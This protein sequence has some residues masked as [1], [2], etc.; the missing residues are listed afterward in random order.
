MAFCSIEGVEE[1]D[2]FKTPFHNTETIRRMHGSTPR[3]GHQS[4]LTR[5]IAEDGDPD[6]D[7][8]YILGLLAS[9]IA[10]F[11]FFSIWITILLVLKCCGPKR[12]GFWS[13]CGSPLPAE[14]QPPKLGGELEASVD[15]E[16][17]ETEAFQHYEED[18]AEWTKKK[19]NSKRRLNIC[20]VVVLFCGTSII[21]C[22]A[23]MV[24][25]GISSLVKTLD[26]GRDFIK[27]V[28]DLTRQAIVLVDLFLDNT[29]KATNVTG[30]LL[31]ATNGFCPKVNEALCEDILSDTN[32]NFTGIPFESEIEKVV[33][34][35]G[36]IRTLIFEDVEKFRDDLVTM[37]DAADEMDE[38]VQT[39]NWAFW[40][41]ASFSL[42][43]AVLCL[44][45][46][47]GVILAWVHKLPRVFYCFRMIV[48][49][50][51]FIFLVLI[52]WI[53][54]MVFVI[55][56]MAVADMCINSPDT[57]ML[58][59]IDKLR[60]KISSIISEFLV[61]YISGKLRDNKMAVLRVRQGTCNRFVNKLTP[62]VRLLIGFNYTIL[63]FLAG[64]SGAPPI[65]LDSE[66]QFAKNAIPA[67]ANFTKTLQGAASEE[68]FKICDRRPTAIGL[69]AT[70]TS[71]VLCSVALTLRGVRVY[72]TCDNWYPLYEGLIYEAVCYEGTDGFAWVAS[73]QFVI[74]FMTMIILTLRITFYEVEVEE[75]VDEEEDEPGDDDQ[76]KSDSL[77]VLPQASKD[78]PDAED[79]STRSHSDEPDQ[80]QVE[81]VDCDEGEEAWERPSIYG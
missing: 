29:K 39:F 72:F 45:V 61:F 65:S 60:S 71:D 15:T 8:D 22:A 62:V 11:C 37:S 68:I 40:I 13:G 23:L 70:I 47:I 5:L 16:G 44:L 81:M 46:M 34:Y 32:C 57:N 1:P 49:V 43:L 10:M 80:P 74:V 51:S 69:A 36:G 41:A 17:T 54:S 48:I 30:D 58:L 73:T 79:T 26:G 52:S 63:F 7:N 33:E 6:D 4:N 64:C 2:F 53:F 55:G 19:K 50:P 3:F 24:S 42:A 35:F 27:L 78:A 21:I 25:Q 18:H 20:R 14:P 76:E 67:F 12:V 77:A 75:V 66:V 56:S 38:K 9:S 31:I 59:L 28:G